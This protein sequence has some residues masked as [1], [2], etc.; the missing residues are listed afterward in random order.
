M[1]SSR[2][3][4]LALQDHSAELIKLII[5]DWLWSPASSQDVL[6]MPSK[7]PDFVEDVRWLYDFSRLP[8]LV[9]PPSLTCKQIWNHQGHHT[10]IWIIG[11]KFIT[12]FL[13]F[14]GIFKIGCLI[15][16]TLGQHQVFKGF[17]S[18][19]R[20]LTD[21]PAHG[22]FPAH[23]FPSFCFQVLSGLIGKQGI[24]TASANFF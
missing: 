22:P 13:C 20:G 8:M 10:R 21:C 24:K 18:F 7:Y 11:E 15:A 6:I 2:E 12:Q 5:H 19:G 1:N 16:V 3:G 14:P 17:D 4:L 23:R 9:L